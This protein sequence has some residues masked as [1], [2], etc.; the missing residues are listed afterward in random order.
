MS[1]EA[2][3]GC[4][5]KNGFELYRLV[6][7]EIDAIFRNA[8]S[9]LDVAIQRLGEKRCSTLEQTKELVRKLDTLAKVYLE[10][11]GYQVPAKLLAK[12]FWQAVD[13][14]G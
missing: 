1:T 14:H 4:H 12:S 6:C 2:A 10:K 9:H 13:E 11:V 8:D 5:G 7:W 3:D